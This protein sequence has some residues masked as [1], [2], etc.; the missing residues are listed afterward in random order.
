M[1][2]AYG[3]A[4][5]IGIHEE[6]QGKRRRR[7]G[8]DAQYGHAPTRG[9]L[10]SGEVWPGT[11]WIGASPP[12]EYGPGSAAATFDCWPSCDAPPSSSSSPSRAR[13]EPRSA[14]CC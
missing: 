7:P 11:P 5:K 9:F 1:G 2:N 3:H 12:I 14:S 8:G 6:M 10:T 13:F 4:A